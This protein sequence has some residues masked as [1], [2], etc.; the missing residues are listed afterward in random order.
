MPME[1]IIRESLAEALRPP[2]V[3]TVSEWSEKNMVL[4]ADYSAS[5]GRFRAY[6]YQNGIM[7]AMTDPK[8][9]TITVMKSARVGYTQ[10]L[11]NAFGYFIHHDP[12]PSRLEYRRF[13]PVDSTPLRAPIPRLERT[14][15]APR[16][17]NLQPLAGSGIAPA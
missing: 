1:F 9:K 17:P 14:P 13:P 11:N 4:S 16:R 5:T 6:P 3:I 10:I 12:S 7:D 15:K 8:N 2:P